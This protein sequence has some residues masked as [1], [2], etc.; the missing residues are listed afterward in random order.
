MA[1]LV[2]SYLKTNSIE[3]SIEYANDCATKVVQKRGVVTL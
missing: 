3:V 2:I 1:S